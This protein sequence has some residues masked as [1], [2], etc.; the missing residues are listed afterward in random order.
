M[1]TICRFELVCELQSRK[2]SV[3]DLIKKASGE[4]TR[5]F[6]INIEHHSIFQQLLSSSRRAMLFQVLSKQ[7]LQV[8]CGAW[9]FK[10]AMCAIR[11]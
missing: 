5:G 6:F 3:A 9:P 4:S 2:L 10:Y 11:V 8:L 1:E 7:G